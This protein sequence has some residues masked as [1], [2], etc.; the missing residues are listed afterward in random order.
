[1]EA[2]RWQKV[3][4]LFNQAVELPVA[5]RQKFLSEIDLEE[6]D[7]RVEVEQMLA[8][9]DD[10]DDSFEKNPFEVIEESGNLP[11]KIG[12]YKIVREIGRGGMGVVYEAL[13][14][15]KD[16]KQRVALKVI[17]RGMDTDAIL[18]RF[19]H[20]QQ[21]LA[22]LEHPSIAR[23]LDGGMTENN[24]AFYAME[25]IEGEF[26]DDYCRQKN[27]NLNERLALFRQVCSAVQYAH[28]NLVIHRD[29]KPSNILVTTDGTP[30]LLDFG[31]GK[32]LEADFL[33]N[34]GTATV[35]G[36][37]TPAY[38]SPEQIR[39]ERVNTATDVYSLGVILFEIL[40][41]QKPYKINS[42]NQ[43]EIQKI[44]C[45]SAPLRPSSVARNVERKLMI[46]KDLLKSE[47]AASEN[48]GQRTKDEGHTT[49]PKS[50]IQNLKSLRG[51]IDNI[52]LK[53]LKKNS[54]ERYASVG[55]FSEDL[56]LHLEGLPITARP[57]TFAYRATKFIKRNRIPVI[58]AVIVF[59]SLCVGI[60][61]A[62]RQTYRAEQQRL[63]AEKRFS[64]VRQIANK[65]VFKYTDAITNLPNSSAAREM[66]LQDASIYLDN[67][68]QDAKDDV[69]L[70]SELAAAYIK[71]SDL[72][73]APY[74]GSVGDVGKAV[75]TMRKAIVIE[76]SVFAAHPSD[77]EIKRTLA[78]AY[79]KF[80]NLIYVL[81]DADET[82]NTYQKAEKLLK[83]L[84]IDEPENAELLAELVRLQM[85]VGSFASES[86]LDMVK[87]R[88][89]MQQA[90][91]VSQNLML[92]K[93]DD[94]ATRSL[95]GS[96]N[97]RYAMLLGHPESSELNDLNGAAEKFR[98][99]IE[100]RRQLMEKAAANISP[101][102]Q[103]MTGLIYLADILVKQQKY[104]EAISTYEDAYNRASALSARDPNDF[105]SRGGVT[106]ALER[107]GKALVLTGQTSAGLDKNRESSRQFE[108]FLAENKFELSIRNGFVIHLIE[109]GG[110][111]RG[112]KQFDEA[113]KVYRRAL[114]IQAEAERDSK[115]FEVITMN[116]PA[117]YVA[118]GILQTEQAET[119]TAN[120]EKLLAEA[121]INLEKGLPKFRELKARKVL[122]ERFRE[123][124]ERAEKALQK[125]INRN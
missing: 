71:L 64:E 51:D 100:T 112:D 66:I 52:L 109:F 56:R 6:D 9:A 122:F 36:M 20:E 19:R 11:E 80:G 113:E 87:A 53:S 73:G 70:Q 84:L 39:G 77:R 41:G 15:T 85:Q 32:I 49:S 102:R 24:L 13:R 50:K 125:I 89:Y 58:A 96:V 18:S 97:M 119:Q 82:L 27:L 10:E 101:Q 79:T 40:T 95:F 75:E 116:G 5:D 117:I 60:G 62:L 46:D 103:Y 93:P 45:E 33:E 65:V 8:F 86:R 81:G 92:L 61:V 98:I 107:W 76:E 37:M 72:Q 123:L 7:I 78:S 118:L 67:L 120:R 12:V 106:R 1:M 105:Y 54:A 114:E 63:L 108:Q 35:L 4:D 25:Y 115:G 74:G 21:I 99:S 28:Q 22:S 91:E 121:K 16:F 17:K 3:K 124:D 83:E 44:I 42:T 48:K 111:L 88:Q 90:L 68:A 57:D 2:E 30:K 14:E 38:A 29:L 94:T 43:Y 55:E 104:P 34:P 59:V 31:I 110:L 47:N 23:F 26:I 69:A